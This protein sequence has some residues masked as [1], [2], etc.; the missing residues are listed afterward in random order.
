MPK[1]IENEWE[2]AQQQTIESQERNISDGVTEGDE[3]ENQP[4]PTNIGI[5]NELMPIGKFT[6]AQL[7]DE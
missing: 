2:D 5:E 1:G 7:S 3:R 6:A 4:L